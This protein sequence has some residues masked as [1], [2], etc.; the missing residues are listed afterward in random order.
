MTHLKAVETTEELITKILSDRAAELKTLD[1]L[2]AT[3][4]K[5]L[6]SSDRALEKATE[7][8]DLQAFQKAKGTRR[9]ILDA[10][11]MHES[12]LEALTTRPLISSEEYERLVSSIFAEIAQVDDQT[13]QELCKLSDA[14][15]ASALELQDAINRANH[16]LQRLQHEIYKDSDKSR[17]NKTGEILPLEFETKA[18]RN[19]STVNWG[20]CGVQAGAYLEY[21]GRKA[22]K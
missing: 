22:A 15:N 10:L 2:I 7:V 16:A 4:K 5:S 3:E 13:K 18:V 21:T 9:N 8:G 20:K 17:S 14:M 1:E 11:E 12:R 19:Y 6:S